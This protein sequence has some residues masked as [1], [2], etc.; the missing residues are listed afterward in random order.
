MAST[1]S[2]HVDVCFREQTCPQRTSFNT[3]LPQGTASLDFLDLASLEEY[4]DTLRQADWTIIVE[5]QGAGYLLGLEGRVLGF[6][7]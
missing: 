7:T 4:N 5:A 6:L 2:D 1:A 3:G